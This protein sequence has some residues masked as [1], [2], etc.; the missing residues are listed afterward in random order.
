MAAQAIRNYRHTRSKY[1][2]RS[3]YVVSHRKLIGHEIEDSAATLSLWIVDWLSTDCGCGFCGRAFSGV[4]E[5]LVSGI[6]GTANYFIF[7]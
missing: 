3:G 7:C 1:C 2:R 4:F 6:H 5:A